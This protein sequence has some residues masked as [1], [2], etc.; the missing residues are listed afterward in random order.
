[1]VFEM[2]IVIGACIKCLVAND[3]AMIIPCSQL[4]KSEKQFSFIAVI[5]GA[6]AL[7][8][9]DHCMKVLT[10]R[11]M[12]TGFV[13]FSALTNDC[14]SY[15]QDMLFKTWMQYFDLLKRLNCDQSFNTK[16]STN[17]FRP[18]VIEITHS[19][20]YSHRQ[21]GK[22]ERIGRIL[23]V[24]ITMLGVELRQIP[25]HSSWV[26]CLPQLSLQYNALPFGDDP[27]SAP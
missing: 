16:N 6:L 22:V 19:G 17:F 27:T 25:H 23:T 3:Y 1:M 13:I 12:T 14:L 5:N 7:P 11:D 2:D 9:R 20:A 18:V 15:L 21:N 26:I 10:V 4:T 8:K 24:C